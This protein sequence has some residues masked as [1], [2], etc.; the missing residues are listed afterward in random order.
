MSYPFKSFIK[1]IVDT[2]TFWVQIVY[3][4]AGL[5]LQSKV[6]LTWYLVFMLI[7]ILTR[8]NERLTLFYFFLGISGYQ[9]GLWLR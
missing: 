9:V 6:I 3:L 2:K 8:F 1:E 7:L 5:T 4:Y